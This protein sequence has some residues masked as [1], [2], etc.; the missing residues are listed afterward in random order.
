MIPEAF[1]IVINGLKQQELVIFAGAGIS[2]AK[3]TSLPLSSH[4]QEGVQKAYLAQND[5]QALTAQLPGLSFKRIT[6][7]EILYNAFSEFACQHIQKLFS[8]LMCDKPNINHKLISALLEK[9]II[10]F[11][12]TTNFDTLIEQ[13]ISGHNVQVAIG[14]EICLTNRSSSVLWKIHGSLS[15]PM[16]ISLRDVCA[17]GFSTIPVHLE[18]H[19]HG[20]IVM[21]AGYSGN[22]I[23]IINSILRGQPKKVV[24]IT[25]HDEIP[26]V[27]RI[28][29]N[30]G[31]ECIVW[32]GDLCKYDETNPFFLVANSFRNFLPFSLP[33]SSI[34]N[35]AEININKGEPALE[36]VFKEIIDTMSPLQK[37]LV[38][39]A[40]IRRSGT[41][42]NSN[43]RKAL[44]Y[45][46][47]L[48]LRLFHNI[49]SGLRFAT[50]SDWVS[51]F[52]ELFTPHLVARE[53][54]SGLP[55]SFHDDEKNNCNADIEID[56]L[57]TAFM[58]PEQ[59]A[60]Y[61]KKL[62]PLYEFTKQFIMEQIDKQDQSETFLDKICK[63]Y[64]NG[65]QALFLIDLGLELLVRSDNAD[66]ARVLMKAWKM[67]D[68]AVPLIVKAKA[69]R[70]CSWIYL[71]ND[72]KKAYQYFDSEADRVAESI[73]KQLEESVDILIKIGKTQNESAGAALSIRMATA[74]LK[75]IKLH[76]RKENSKTNIIGNKQY[77]CSTDALIERLRDSFCSLSNNL[78]YSAFRQ[79]KKQTEGIRPLDEPRAYEDFDGDAWFKDV[80]FLLLL[81]G[82]C[83]C[84]N[85][86]RLAIDVAHHAISRIAVV[87]NQGVLMK[88]MSKTSLGKRINKMGSR[89][90][91]YARLE[92]GV[93]LFQMGQ[94][95]EAF[96]EFEKSYR[97]FDNSNLLEGIRDYSKLTKEY[98]VQGGNF[99][100]AV[101]AVLEEDIVYRLPD[102]RKLL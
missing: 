88:I 69:A 5:V 56:N 25:D 42:T 102:N 67:C 72:D 33:T 51:Y 43:Y 79:L 47:W 55:D 1:E 68:D 90:E 35:K 78:K 19:I 84:L 20:K 75:A 34:I 94:H 13:C 61:K 4:I 100:K 99:G 10:E 11:A 83:R 92:L 98:L 76:S 96:E 17:V 9:G 53:Y 29:K 87:C 16:S 39:N 52:E 7:P 15:E 41:S 14:E 101:T 81:C 24:W 18:K 30:N 65:Q 45:H 37:G 74:L 80:Q 77:S 86:Y 28:L 95:S 70:A 63:K 36:S 71:K 3:P 12:V 54:L 32:R 22:D 23:W 66:A 48:G 6:T 8:I 27:V 50:N 2:Y 93:S 26:K 62:G 57:Q 85:R 49:S 59:L 38:L 73:E 97:I 40:L 64:S 60:E 91:G 46:I 44:S 89:Y 82:I 31:V 58:S 21:F